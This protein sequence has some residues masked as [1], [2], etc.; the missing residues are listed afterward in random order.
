MATGIDSSSSQ[1]DRYC[2]IEQPPARE[3]ALLAAKKDPQCHRATHSHRVDGR[4]QLT[5]SG[6]FECKFVGRPPQELQYDCPVCLQIL[7]QPHQ[8]KC[9]G[10]GFCETCIQLVQESKKPCPTCNTEDFS[11]FPDKSLRQRLYSFRAYCCHKEEGCDWEGELRDL[12]KHL[13]LQPPPEKISLGC[14][15][16]EVECTYCDH[17]YQRR[18]V[19]D[20]QANDCPKRPFTCEHCKVYASTFED[21]T[22][23]HWPQC[24]FFPVA[25][26][27]KCGLTLPRGNVEVHLSS[28][29]PLVVVDCEF[30]S[31][32]CSVQLARKD[33]P[34]HVSDNLVDH[35]VL[36]QLQGMTA[37]GEDVAV[38]MTLLAASIHKIACNFS[39]K[40]AVAEETICCQ[41][42]EI[43]K[44]E[45]RQKMVNYELM[46]KAFSREKWM[47]LHHQPV[48]SPVSEFTVSHFLKQKTTGIDWYSPPFYTSTR[49]YRMCIKVNA[50]GWDSGKGTHISVLG[51]LMK[52]DFDKD[53]LWPFHN[54]ITI[55]L[56]N[57]LEDAH[58]RAHC[59]HFSEIEHPNVAHRVMSGERA[60][61]G[62]GKP[63]FISHADLDLNTDRNTLYLKDDRLK[64]RVF[65][66]DILDSTACIQRRGQSQEMFTEALNPQICTGSVGFTLQH[67]QWHKSR[68]AYWHSPAFYTHDKG[69]RMCLEVYPNGSGKGWGHYVSVFTCLMQGPFD[70]D[71]EWPFRGHITVEIVNQ[72]CDNHHHQTTIS[73]ASGTSDSVADRVREKERAKST[74]FCKALP[75]SKLA[76]ES[77]NSE[78]KIHVLYLKNDSLQIRVLN[79]KME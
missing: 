13:N 23:N 78:M 38:Y 71:L 10:K 25:C 74:G 17:F 31:L 37:R 6:G 15:F 41:Q 30:K 12:E 44:L 65:N 34:S 68:D 61:A 50:N 46:S 7:R 8:T 77:I 70:E 76:T 62:W 16:S 63:T 43:K 2:G 19:G 36:L 20:H 4:P 66:G 1:S 21:T 73:Y 58:H 18:Y 55:Q 35:L 24:G 52:G 56:L 54:D 48:Q 39:T 5:Q 40:L 27:Q 22:E 26:T 67:F 64:F 69:Y 59:I 49:G 47:C 72:E 45:A 11:T 42:R 79:V 29:C 57:Q 53:L 9:C 51:Y 28:D 60:K 32:G 75:H 33:M 14:P 3:E